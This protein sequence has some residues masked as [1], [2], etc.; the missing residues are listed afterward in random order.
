LFKSIRTDL[1]KEYIDALETELK[2]FRMHDD[3]VLVSARLGRANRGED[4]ILHRLPFAGPAWWSRIV[5]TFT[6]RG[7]SY[8]FDVDPRDQGGVRAIT[9]LRGQGVLIAAEALGRAARHVHGFFSALRAELAFLVGCLNLA[10]LL[11]RSG[12]PIS[13]PV[14]SSASPGE[15]SYRGL[16]DPHLVQ[17]L[18]S[19]VVGN[20]TEAGSKPLLVITGANTGGKS[21]LLRAL[22]TAQLM[23][24][25]GMFVTAESFAGPLCKGVFTHFRKEED[26]GMKQ[27][28]FEE[29]LT[30]MDEIVDHLSSGSLLLMNE[31]FASTNEREGAAIARDIIRALLTRGVRVACVTHLFELSSGLFRCNQD[32]GHFLRASRGEGGVRTFKLE[33]GEPLQ[34]SFALDVYRKVFIRPIQPLDKSV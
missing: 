20:D 25:A 6:R 29:E 16:Y 21:T 12:K 3:S 10:D 26:A 13:F 27:G 17:A 4:Y 24:Q 30:R 22:G 11:R 1:S 23:M 5:A 2:L 33:P 28:K 9:N 32:V 31:S 15:F 14:V 18:G 8:G 34:T 19:G 7:N